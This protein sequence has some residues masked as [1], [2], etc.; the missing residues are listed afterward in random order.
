MTSSCGE[1]A[2]G[3]ETASILELFGELE[4]AL[5]YEELPETVLLETEGSS[6]PLLSSVRLSSLS[7]SSLC[8][9]EDF[10][11]GF[12]L[13]ELLSSSSADSSS[14]DSEEISLF[15]LFWTDMS[16]GLSPWDES[17]AVE[18]TL[19]LTGVSRQSSDVLDWVLLTMGL[20]MLSS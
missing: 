10:L 15:L 18:A 8:I 20:S 13:G 5:A 2:G 12:D 16:I 4:A 19:P 11:L 3:L 7:L 6:S 17:I 9:E 14:S 1:L